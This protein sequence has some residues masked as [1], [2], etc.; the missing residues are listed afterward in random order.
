VS[1]LRI[2]GFTD[3]GRYNVTGDL[4]I[5][6]VIDPPP[7]QELPLYSFC[8]GSPRRFQEHITTPHPG[9][10]VNVTGPSL[11][12]YVEPDDVM[13]ARFDA[14]AAQAM[15]DDDD[16]TSIWNQHSALLLDVEGLV[17]A[18]IHSGPGDGT[19]VDRIQRFVHAWTVV[20][21]MID[22]WR[23][24]LTIEFFPYR[25]IPVTADTS[26]N[27]R[28][29]N[30]HIGDLFVA[31]DVACA[32][33]YPFNNP[34]YS[35]FNVEETLRLAPTGKKVVALFMPRMHPSHGYRWLKPDEFEG[36]VRQCVQTEWEGRTVDAVAM[37]T[38]GIYDLRKIWNP[39]DSTPKAQRDRV[40]Y[41]ADHEYLGIPF[42][43]D[44]QWNFLNEWDRV[45]LEAMAKG[46]R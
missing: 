2:D 22:W 24:K 20:N 45:N 13:T 30:D 23:E 5:V 34:R 26:E 17:L 4:T 7:S 10:S 37:W 25:L 14:A 15:Y 41:R 36:F 18:T 33:C 39:N 40:L 9:P 42:E 16:W 8:H 12:I 35:T 44:E 29:R 6:Q 1:K 38:A 11:G 3:D 32:H 21:T 46:T 31:Y 28:R 43:K 27:Q 19:D